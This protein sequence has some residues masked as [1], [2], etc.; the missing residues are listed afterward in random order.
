MRYGKTSKKTFSKNPAI[1]TLASELR[2]RLS[3]LIVCISN[4]WGGLEQVAANDSLDLAQVGI[5]TKVLCLEKSPIH[6]YL[7][8]AEGIECVAIDFTPRNHFD[9][10]LKPILKKLVYEQG[11][12]LIHTH[13]PS[14][15]GSIVPW[16]WR[17]PDLIIMASRHIMNG[18]DKRDLFHRLLYRRLDSMIAMSQTL[19]KNI[20]ATHP[21]KDKQVKVIRLGLD[22]EEFDPEKV[23][24]KQ[25]RKLWGA[26]EETT[27]IGLVGRIDPAKGQ[28]TFIKAAA[29]LSKN[30]KALEKLK[31]VIV[32]EE[33]LGSTGEYL[34]E[35]KEM[36]KQFRLEDDVV[37][38]GYQENIPEV[39]S[40]FDLFVMPSRQEAFGLVAIEAM[41]MECPIV[42]S[43]GGSA[44][45]IIGKEEYGL[46]MRPDDAFDMQ[47]RIRHLL[48]HSEVRATM[49]KGA[50][51]YVVQNYDRWVRIQKTLEIYEWNLRKRG[52]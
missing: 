32:G 26:D 49:G 34:E 19:R 4:S 44:E 24:A 51:R 48:N 18:H 12:N 16:L 45:E 42:I 17:K 14:L 2:S 33:T 47:S 1:E 10:K 52:R 8:E 50:R 40:A 9:F 6:E 41:A 39:M 3:P 38:A 31:F 15:L 20:L 21:L 22:F 27:V 29:G 37:F 13:Q 36:V 7:K 5:S 35:L 46:L 30:K 25:Q 23:E 11:I 28:A 43:S